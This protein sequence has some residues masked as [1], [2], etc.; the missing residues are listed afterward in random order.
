MEESIAY[1]D[2]YIAFS[3]ILGF[4]EMI[5]KSNNNV[6]IFN[7]IVLALSEMR[8]LAD[9]PASLAAIKYNTNISFAN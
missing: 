2:R 1:Q 5:H 6:K 3:D 9:C 4:R 7:D 8:N